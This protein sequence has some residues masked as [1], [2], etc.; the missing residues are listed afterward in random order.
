MCNVECESTGACA[1][2]NIDTDN[3]AS[4]EC[5]GECDG[6]TIPAPFTRVDTTQPLT[7]SNPRGGTSNN[8]STTMQPLSTTA[9]PGVSTSID[10]TQPLF[11]TEM[12]TQ[13]LSDFYTSSVDTTQSISSTLQTEDA[14]IETTL[15]TDG[16]MQEQ[17]VIEKT[18][19]NE[20]NTAHDDGDEQDTN[21]TPFHMQILKIAKEMWLYIVIGGSAFCCLCTCGIALIF[22]RRKQHVANAEPFA[23]KDKPGPK[24][25]SITMTPVPSNTATP[26]TAPSAT[27]TPVLPV[28]PSKNNKMSLCV[29]RDSQPQ[30]FSEYLENEALAGSLVMD[31]VVHNMVTTPGHFDDDHDAYLSPVY[32][33]NE[34][35][36]SDAYGN[37]DQ[38][39]NDM[40]TARATA[41]EDGEE[42][43]EE[44]ES[45]LMTALVN[46]ESDDGMNG[47]VDEEDDDILTDVNQ[48]TMRGTGE[49]A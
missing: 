33:V 37:D 3:A 16:P 6:N 5:H 2:I 31:D 35:G 14:S 18:T 28:T 8:L 7:T 45:E 30:S 19:Q 25:I 17:E 34:G 1:D 12:T 47:D 43:G 39:L 4:F 9:Q 24:P 27:T 20:E 21:N 42:Q 26:V 49:N 15:T 32:L 40:N 13:S 38:I 29:I 22:R 48:M 41:D 46:G 44:D 11:T 10:T 23:S 36:L